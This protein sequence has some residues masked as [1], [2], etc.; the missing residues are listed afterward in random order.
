MKEEINVKST[1]T[2]NLPGQKYMIVAVN[3]ALTINEASLVI[4]QALAKRLEYPVGA[5][6][7]LQV[8]GEISVII[9]GDM[10]IERNKEKEKHDQY[11]KAAKENMKV[12][13]NKIYNRKSNE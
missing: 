2:I 4:K 3:E 7:I 6:G 11:L 5:I 9:K 13:L 1:H 8:E 12:T 10:A